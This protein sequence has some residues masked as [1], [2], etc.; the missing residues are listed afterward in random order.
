MEFFQ[1]THK[2]IRTDRQSLQWE[3]SPGCESR[4]A[5]EFVHIIGELKDPLSDLGFTIANRRHCAKLVECMTGDADPKFQLLPLPPGL[6]ISAH[7][8]TRVILKHQFLACE[9]ATEYIQ[10]VH[11]ADNPARRY[12]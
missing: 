11:C 5:F 1:T 2:G 4:R 7:I 10:S 3:E 12:P 6:L 8:R 9:A